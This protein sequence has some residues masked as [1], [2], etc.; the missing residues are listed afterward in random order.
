[1]DKGVLSFLGDKGKDP[2]VGKSVVNGATDLAAV[3]TF[4]TYLTTN[5]TDCVK[6]YTSW[7]DRD[8]AANP[9]PGT[10]VNVDE[11][12]IFVVKEDD[13]SIHKFAIPGPKAAI[14]TL[15]DEGR[16]I[17]QAIQDAFASALSTCTGRTFSAVQ[18]YVII[19]K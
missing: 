16:R 15:E 14:W 5:V 2:A 4:M 3:N 19:K 8:D 18:G 17:T 11:L 13:G 10:D 12:A 7:C 6:N 9:P 1:M